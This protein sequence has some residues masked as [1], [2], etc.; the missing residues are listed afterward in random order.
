MQWKG[1]PLFENFWE[2]MSEFVQQYPNYQ[3]GDKLNLQRGSVDRAHNANARPQIT[4]V[5]VRKR[6]GLRSKPF[7]GQGSE[8][9]MKG[10]ASGGDGDCN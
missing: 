2:L 6:R 3:L 10:D 9:S 8:D 1:L 5:Y 7:E 4:N